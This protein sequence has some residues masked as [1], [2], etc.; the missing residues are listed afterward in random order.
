MNRVT[1]QKITWRERE[2]AK[3]KQKRDEETRRAEEERL[4]GVRMTDTNF[5]ALG[6]AGAPRPKPAT[7]SGLFAKMASDWKKQEDL[8]A[9]REQQRRE[10]EER[11]LRRYSS[12]PAFQASRPSRFSPQAEDMCPPHEEVLQPEWTTVDT[13]KTRIQRDLTIE[14]MEERDR[15]EQEADAEDDYEQNADVGDSSRRKFY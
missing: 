14:E 6:G 4:R 5:P 8:D 11:E 10:E 1:P 15:A 13:R 2:A 3:E 9:F 7:Q 12:R